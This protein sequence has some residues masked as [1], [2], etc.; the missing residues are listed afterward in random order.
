MKAR[1]KLN[2]FSKDHDEI[3]DN[4]SDPGE[5]LYNGQ[6]QSHRTSSGLRKGSSFYKVIYTID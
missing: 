2:I 3:C 1:E 6:E 4:E 5:S